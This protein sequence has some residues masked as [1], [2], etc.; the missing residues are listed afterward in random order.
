MRTVFYTAVIGALL[1]ACLWAAM[2]AVERPTAPQ[3]APLAPSPR[4]IG[5]ELR[6]EVAALLAAQG[7]EYEINELRPSPPDADRLDAAERVDLSVWTEDGG[8]LL[9]RI[10]AASR[11]VTRLGADAFEGSSGDAAPDSGG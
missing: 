6:A 10:D 9:Y 4:K 8:V 7:L 3:P 11:T 2:F 5:S 1:T